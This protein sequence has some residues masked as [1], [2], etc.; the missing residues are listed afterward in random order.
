MNEG[1][2]TTKALLLFQDES[3][4]PRASLVSTIRNNAIKGHLAVEQAAAAFSVR[5]LHLQRADC[6]FFSASLFHETS[7]FWNRCFI[8]SL[9][10]RELILIYTRSSLICILFISHKL[11][12]RERKKM[13]EFYHKCIKFRLT[14]TSN[15]QLE[16]GGSIGRCNYR[17]SRSH[18]ILIHFCSLIFSVGNRKFAKQWQ[19]VCSSPSDTGSSYN[20]VGTLF[21]HYSRAD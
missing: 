14:F 3:N 16:I 10:Q 2:R 15:F 8:Y 1:T 5:A 20:S 9:F 19:K 7:L 18:G 6:D 21:R 12:E 11:R 4:R 17:G 13:W